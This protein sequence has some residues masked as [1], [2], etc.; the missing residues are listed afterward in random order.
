MFSQST[1]YSV[2]QFYCVYVCNRRIGYCMHDAR[3]VNRTPCILFHTTVIASSRH[4]G[5]RP[6]SITHTPT[7]QRQPV[8]TT[9]AVSTQ[10][11][12]DGVPIPEDHDVSRRA[13]S[14]ALQPGPAASPRRKS[15]LLRSAALAPEPIPL[16]LH[17]SSLPVL[18]LLRLLVLPRC[19]FLGRMLFS[20]AAA[21]SCSVEPLSASLCGG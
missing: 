19:T 3:T 6:T 2:C 21:P 12:C 8:H 16:P 1:I 14:K 18:S 11:T 15:R 20:A 4:R 5:A 7:D 17:L 10:A 13:P 9:T